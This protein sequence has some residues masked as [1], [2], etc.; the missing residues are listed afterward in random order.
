MEKKDEIKT[1][2][3]LGMYSSGNER[4]LGIRTAHPEFVT[5]M[6]QSR[7]PQFGVGIARIPSQLVLSTFSSRIISAD[8]LRPKQACTEG[9]DEECHI[10]VHEVWSNVC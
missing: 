10:S 3:I 1:E 2:V 4:F 7:G 6:C 5:V 8:R 9:S